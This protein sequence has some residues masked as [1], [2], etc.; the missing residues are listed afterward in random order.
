VVP[1]LDLRD[2]ET[3]YGPVHALKGICMRVEPERIT[4]V[5]GANGAGKSTLLKTV[6][7]LLKG[8]PIRGAILLQGERIDGRST[9][10]IVRMG[11]SCVPEGRQVFE[12]LTVRENLAMGAY[13]R[14]DRG[15]VRNDLEGVYRRFPVLRERQAQWAGTLSAGE[16]QLLAVGRALMNRPKLL[17]LD[18]PSLG[19]APLMVKEI[20]TIIEQLHAGGM[21]I[22]LIEQNARAAL[23]LAHHALVLEN[24]HLALSG[25][26]EQLLRHKGIRKA[27]LGTR[28]TAEQ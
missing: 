20:F 13:I 4:A 17:F 6:M 25:D 18:E 22:A 7:G 15:G 10:A 23:R 26:R 11:I 1:L 14:R 9:E 24:G 21:G 2:V 12:Q 3:C 8:Q 16:Q 27:Y 5:L 28:A 19:L